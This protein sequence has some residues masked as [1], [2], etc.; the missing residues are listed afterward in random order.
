MSKTAPL[1]CG[2]VATH[3]ADRSHY[4]PLCFA[5]LSA[6][7]KRHAPFAEVRVADTA[8]EAV[9]M[10]PDLVGITAS[11]TNI[12]AAVALARQIKESLGVPLVLGGIHV[13]IDLPLLATSSAFDTVAATP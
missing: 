2:L 13:N 5:Y 3:P 7:A 12:K 1:F 6:Y 9:A 10:R 8:R 11:S 4:R